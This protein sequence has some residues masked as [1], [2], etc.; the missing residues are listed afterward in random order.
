MAT[1]AEEISSR[2]GDFENF[3]GNFVYAIDA[4]KEKTLYNEV[5]VDCMHPSISGHK[6]MSEI[7]WN[8]SQDIFE[9]DN[10]DN[11]DFSELPPV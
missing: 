2:S 7:F 5:S 10:F 6:A 8:A 11:Y 3:T 1:L 9:E 4:E